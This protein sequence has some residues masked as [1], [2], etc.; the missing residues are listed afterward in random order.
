MN[1][2]TNWGFGEVHAFARVGE[3]VSPTAPSASPLAGPPGSVLVTVT[4]TFVTCERPYL[5]CD[6]WS[7]D[8]LLT[9]D[10][11]RRSGE[12]SAM[13]RW[14]SGYTPDIVP[15]QCIGGDA[16]IEV[17]VE[18]TE[19]SD[20]EIAGTVCGTGT[21]LEGSFRASFCAP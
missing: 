3:K 20:T 12:F 19:V 7:L 13:A 1:C 14:Y 9:P 6:G 5:T 17:S 8:V 4:Q 10:D 21:G 2:A 16:L 18:L 11:L 15:Y